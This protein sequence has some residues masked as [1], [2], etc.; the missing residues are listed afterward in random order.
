[1]IC[2]SSIDS[3]DNLEDEDRQEGDGDEGE[4]ENDDNDDEYDESYES[5]RVFGPRLEV[6]IFILR[7]TINSGNFPIFCIVRLI[8]ADF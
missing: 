3:C 4:G 1:M 5:A 7:K 8:F 2:G 6:L